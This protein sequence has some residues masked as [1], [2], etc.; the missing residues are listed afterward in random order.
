[1]KK[2]EIQVEVSNIL[3]EHL[4]VDSDKIKDDSDF[5]SDLGADSL[6]AVE[7][8]MAIEEHFDIEIPDEE[9]ET[10]TTVQKTVDVIIAKL[11]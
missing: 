7:I 2:E 1:M 9:A 3:V 4:G 5:V 6:D 11:A 8:I 10:M